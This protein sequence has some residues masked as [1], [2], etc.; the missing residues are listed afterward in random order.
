LPTINRNLREK[1]KGIV[2]SVIMKFPASVVI[3]LGLPAVSWAF[4]VPVRRQVAI[5]HQQLAADPVAL[6]MSLTAYET[7]LE[8]NAQFKEGLLYALDQQSTLSDGSA[9]TSTIL[10]ATAPSTSS[11]SL[12]TLALNVADALRGAQS[13]QSLSPQTWSSQDASVDRA[14]E[15]IQSYWLSQDPTLASSSMAAR[16]PLPIS[17]VPISPV[18]SNVG[19]YESS[20]PLLDYVTSTLFSAN[21]GGVRSSGLFHFELPSDYEKVKLGFEVKKSLLDSL[22]D[23]RETSIEALQTTREISE[24]VASYIIEQT[25]VSIQNSSPLREDIAEAL[26]SN[27][28]RMKEA[29][30][31]FGPYFL[32]QTRQSIDNSAPAREVIR[33][34]LVANGEK[35]QQATGQVASVLNRQVQ[36]SWE[37]TAPV[38]NQ[39]KTTML[40][41]THRVQDA[42][43][44]VGSYLRQQTEQ[45][46]ANTA[47]QIKAAL[48]VN[49]DRVTGS[50]EQF[51]SALATSGQRLQE[52]N[53]QVLETMS[54]NTAAVGQ[55]WGETRNQVAQ[56]QFPEVAA[57]SLTLPVV[58]VPDLPAL[59]WAEVVESLKLQ[60]LGGWYAGAIVGCLLLA[61]ANEQ[62]AS[63]PTASTGS[64]KSKKATPKPPAKATAVAADAS[65]D[66][67]RR[68]EGM[69]VELTQAVAIL[70][71]ELKYLK[72]DR[73]QTSDALASLQSDV[74]N[75]KK[76]TPSAVQE[77][78]LRTELAQS[79][80]QIE[81]LNAQ[82][83]AFRSE[84]NTV[85]VRKLCWRC[86][87]LLESEC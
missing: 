40:D 55:V 32:D 20:T 51:Q 68:L 17:S 22:A 62:K 33:S 25:K 44:Q 37:G 87:V 16:T 34:A 65:L 73:A 86:P 83:E 75:V 28:E 84:V 56:F 43:A 10:T 80:A 4:A 18:D 42:G 27:G 77:Q 2:S 49:S 6:Q 19:G 67:K 11:S 72:S 1:A 66:E 7:V 50:A 29:S 61:V 52:T 39:I 63:V 3:W 53:A 13:V 31:K 59:S 76:S 26:V 38:R 47:S 46:Y 69:V 8:F 41:N 12:D 23:S 35:A 81:N 58:A 24:T 74:N 85:G 64:P 82:L 45:S 54:A 57:P 21:E 70:T 48:L 5:R 78:Q 36:Q 71:N 9:V 30:A 79:D 14:M 15:R 60:E